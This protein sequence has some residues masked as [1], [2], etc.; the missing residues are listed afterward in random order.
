MGEKIRLNQI[1]AKGT[2]S[3]RQKDLLPEGKYPVYGAAGIAGYLNSYQFEQEYLA[4]VKDGAG[5]GRVQLC[6][7]KSSVLGTLQPIIPNDS[8]KLSYLRFML[9]GLHLESYASGATIPHIYFRDY[10]ERLV[11]L[12]DADEQ[13]CV[14]CLFETILKQIALGEQMLAKADELIQSRFVEMFGDDSFAFVPLDQIA[15]VQ[16]GLT[17]N[18]KRQKLPLQLPYLRVANV[19]AGSLD[20]T[21]IK[22]IGLTESERDKTMLETGDLLF[23]EGNGSGDQIGRSAIWKGEIDC[24]V[25]QNHLIRARFHDGI[26]PSFALYYFNSRSGRRQI[27]GKAVST[28]GLYTLSTGKIKSLKLPLPPVALQNEFAEFVT[29]VESLKSTA[30]QQLDRLNTLYASL[31]QRYFAQ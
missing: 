14:T 31:T 22:T 23:V 20:L 15:D 17:K 11:D 2:S 25:H 6:D 5:V 24:C 27:I 10:G 7:R 8:V 26:L 28:S 16:G 19:L 18:S 21:E 29:S 30:R 9:E 12:P 13:E 1:C 4:V 3:L